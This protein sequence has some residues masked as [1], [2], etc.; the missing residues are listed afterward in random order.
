L[1]FRAFIADKPTIPAIQGLPTVFTQPIW[2]REVG[3][4]A[5]SA[6]KLALVADYLSGLLPLLVLAVLSPI[7][8]NISHGYPLSG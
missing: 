5:G 8:P 1:A 2:I 6:V 3:F 4:L 7:I